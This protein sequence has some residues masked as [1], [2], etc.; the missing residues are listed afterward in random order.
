MQKNCTI[1]EATVTFDFLPECLFPQTVTRGLQQ[2]SMMRVITVRDLEFQTTHHNPNA[3]ESMSAFTDGLIS[4][5]S[6]TLL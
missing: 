4:F 6:R 3:G 2:C 5:A 1:L